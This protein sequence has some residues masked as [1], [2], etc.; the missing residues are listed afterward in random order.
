MKILFIGFT[1]P[2]HAS[3]YM[4]KGFRALGHEV[5]HI[6]PYQNP[7]IGLTKISEVYTDEDFVYVFH[8]NSRRLIADVP[9]PVVYYH[10]EQLWRATIDECDILIM[11]SPVIENGLVYWFPE[12]FKRNPA[13]YIQYYGV[14][15]DRFDAT[16]KKKYIEC[17]FMGKIIWEEKCWMERDIYKT[18]REVVESCEPYLNR[19]PHDDYEEYISNLKHS[20]STLIVHGRSCYIS[21]RIFEA[22]AASCCPII[23]VDDEIG[24]KIYRSIGLVHSRNCIF[25]Y[26]EEPK[27]ELDLELKIKDIITIGLNAR[28][29]VES[30]NNI[31]NCKEVIKYVEAYNKRIEKYKEQCSLRATRLIESEL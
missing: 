23:Y 5:N 7:L 14:D 25:L 16:G 12:V 8:N 31:N 19:M 6:D 27:E 1:D 21:Q 15:L 20:Q 29:W 2:N 24:E 30:R 3:S 22:A 28:K 26:G 4:A 10:F 18:R 17:S 11:S 13:K 9:V